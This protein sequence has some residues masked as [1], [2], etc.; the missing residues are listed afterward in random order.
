MNRVLILFL[1]V[2]VLSGCTDSS[3]PSEEQPA[4]SRDLFLPSSDSRIPSENLA[5]K[6]E[7]F[8]APMGIAATDQY[9][10][11]VNSAS[12][13]NQDQV[14]YA[15]G[16]V[17]FIDRAS[18]QIIQ[19]I[20]T[21]GLNPQDIAIN[22]NQIFILSTGK[23]L[24]FPNTPA[25]AATDGALDIL[26]LK[27]GTLPE[28]MTQSILLGLNTEDPRIGAYRTIALSP[29]GNFAFI[30]S[31]TRGDVFKIDLLKKQVMRGAD[32]PIVIFPTLDGQSGYSLVKALDNQQIAILNFNT[33]ELC[34]SADI[35]DDFNNRI[36]DTIGINRK[37]LEGPIDLALAPNGN[38]LV[39]MTI[40]QGL[41][42][43]NATQFPFKIDNNFSQT[44]Q[45]NNRILIH[46]EY[47]YIVNS[48]SNNIQR[49]HLTS[50]NSDLPFAVLPVKS[51]PYDMV[52][53]HEAD[54]DMAWITL[55]G[56]NQVAIVS[57]STGEVVSILPPAS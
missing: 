53:T 39:L 34:L 36:C 19:K 3:S 40:A 51:N 35:V 45:A 13:Y 20:P 47:A 38:L 44:G 56:S 41:Y 26:D 24:F 9:I 30:G 37:L 4:T 33:D 31:G 42:Q 1:W 46:G 2:N 50:K 7:A 6:S 23:L 16:F 11:V 57:L 21:S 22:K 27:S 43:V 32:N 55:Q 48:A 28:K 15:P 52:I 25:I 49:I 14:E 8:Y 10:V 17:T 18:H 12:Y 54:G 5:I 29:D